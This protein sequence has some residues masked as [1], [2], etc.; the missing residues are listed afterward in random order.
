M[1]T[2]EADEHLQA[3]TG[4]ARGGMPKSLI[5]YSGFFQV[6]SRSTVAGLQLAGYFHTLVRFCELVS[7]IPTERRGDSRARRGPLTDVIHGESETFWDAVPKQ[8][9]KQQTLVAYT[10]WL[11]GEQED[12]IPIV[13]DIPNPSLEAVPGAFNKLF[14]MANTIGA[15]R[16]QI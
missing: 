7:M 5:L 13:P 4:G 1:S 8:V 15:M 2:F 11:V 12:E 3:L 16:E 10:N 14:Y 9:G 6:S